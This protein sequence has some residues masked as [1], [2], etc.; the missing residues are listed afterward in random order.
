MKVLKTKIESE[1]EVHVGSSYVKDYFETLQFDDSWSFRG[2]TQK[3]TNYVTHGYHR[4]PAKFIPQLAARLITEI[5]KPGDLV[6]DPF[7]G[8]G[9]TLVEAKILGR[10]S[11][12]VDINPVAVL[13]AQAKITPIV[14]DVLNLHFTKLAE[15]IWHMESAQLFTV[16]ETA[17]KYQAKTPDIDRIDYWFRPKTKKKLSILFEKIT[18]IKDDKVRTFFLCGFSNILK[19][20]SIWMQKSNKPTR[21]FSKIIPDPYTIFLKHVKRMIMKN[22]EFWNLLQKNDTINVIAKPLC[23]DARKVPVDDDSVSLVVTSPPYVTSY[24]YADLHQ[25]S[26]LWFN[27]TNS[28]PE[29]RQ[30]FI[31]SSANGTQRSAYYINSKLGKEI[32]NQLC[33]KRTGK[34]SEVAK[35]FHEMRES[36][37]EMKRYLKPGGKACIVIGDTCFRG[38]PVLN[39]EVFVEQMQNVG[40]KI[41]K[42]IKRII[43][44][45]NLP[46][47]RD[48]KT[49]KFTA[50]SNQDRILAYP[51]EFII[52]MEKS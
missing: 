51:F 2:L 27:F 20:C 22:A 52:I 24:E 36:F 47:T 4:Y 44:S 12:G 42:I 32:V 5:T 15:T 23:A 8:S 45:K 50:S 21:D 38:V 9:T 10:P 48:P 18:G 29:F 14:P 3:D 46:Q 13:I 37:L 49:G 11:V 7:M 33:N 35:Y 31:G 28:L 34:S 1:N 41:S 30:R 26:A 6:V 43:P 40:F 16:T 17:V 19:N 39:A 25:L